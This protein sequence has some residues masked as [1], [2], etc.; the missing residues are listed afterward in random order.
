MDRPGN[1]RICRTLACNFSQLESDET[2]SDKGPSS[3]G[4]SV[5]LYQQ[6]SPRQTP[7]GLYAC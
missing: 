2:N 1:V 7:T 6:V 4:Q 5:M 3:E